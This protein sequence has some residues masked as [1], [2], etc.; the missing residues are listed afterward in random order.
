MSTER[1]ARQ[2]AIEGWNP[3]ALQ[4]NTVAVTGNGPIT[5]FTIAYLAGLNFKNIRLFSSGATDFRIAQDRESLV[6][7]V[8]DLSPEINIESINRPPLEDDMYL[9]DIDI[10]VDTSNQPY[11]KDRNFKNAKRYAKSFIS[12][13]SSSTKASIVMEN[14][15]RASSPLEKVIMNKKNTLQRKSDAPFRKID[16]HMHEFEK[17]RQGITTSSAIAALVTDKI[18]SAIMPLKEEN[19]KGGMHH[20]FSYETSNLEKELYD[21][22]VL[23]VGAGGVGTYIAMNCA[24]SNIAEMHIADHDTVSISNL[25]RQIL[26]RENDAFN[27][28]NKAE[29]ICQSLNDLKPAIYKPIPKKISKEDESWIRA[30]NYDLIFSAPDNPSTRKELDEIA[31]AAG[32]PLI[33]GG[34]TPFSSTMERY[35][36][37]KTA[38]LNCQNEHYEAQIRY[39]NEY[40]ETLS[41]ATMQESN[42]VVTNAFLGALMTEE[43]LKYFNGK[44]LPFN[45]KTEFSIENNYKLINTPVERCT[46][47]SDNPCECQET[48]THEPKKKKVF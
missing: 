26:Y 24:L 47:C 43:A 40:L 27:N 23:L 3:Q 1:T 14:F 9:K 42:V 31:Y 15:S 16:Y 46:Y 20:E 7:L 39:F 38:C 44:D 18:R 5:G 21:K 28:H 22:K 33:N 8:K 6:S 41:C 10:I 2:D 29:A 17:Y 12:A 45:T 32:I 35:I 25:N 4:D 48:I 37:G 36:P 19:N 34:I 11:F 13:S 30:E